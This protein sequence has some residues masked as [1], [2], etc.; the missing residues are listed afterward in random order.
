MDFIQDNKQTYFAA[1]FEYLISRCAE[2]EKLVV[3][4]EINEEVFL[5]T[6][7]GIRNLKIGKDVYLKPLY[8]DEPL[9]IGNHINYYLSRNDKVVYVVNLERHRF[10]GPNVKKLV[11]GIDILFAPDFVVNKKEYRIKKEIIA[12][13]KIYKSKCI[14][15]DRFDE[16][17]FYLIRLKIV[18][19]LVDVNS[20]D[21]SKIFA[22]PGQNSVLPFKFQI[23]NR[24]SVVYEERRQLYNSFY[25]VENGKAEYIKIT[26]KNRGDSLIVRATTDN[27]SNIITSDFVL[28][29]IKADELSKHIEVFNS[30]YGAFF[31]DEF[32]DLYKYRKFEKTRYSY[33]KETYS[34]PASVVFNYPESSKIEIGIRSALED[35]VIWFSNYDSLNDPFDLSGRI[36]TRYSVEMNDFYKQIV[37]TNYKTIGTNFLTFCST[38]REDN[39]LMWSHYGDS[40]KGTCIRYPMLDIIKTI[41]ND[42]GI[43][44]CFYGKVKYK[45][46]RPVFSI[47]FTTFRFV[48]IQLAIL[49]FNII[50]MFEK[51]KDWGY[52]NEFRFLII[53]SSPAS[54][55][56]ASTLKGSE[57]ILGNN[58]PV[59]TYA[60]YI[61]NFFVKHY[62]LKLSDSEYKLR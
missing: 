53:P 23:N 37:A 21:P 30:I 28:D 62:Q 60:S 16:F 42:K 34:I 3:S 49:R 33:D 24:T 35:N 38:S 17:L 56:Y 48:D 45:R 27:R 61:S 43:G 7:T 6:E 52:E 14:H 32:I 54:S 57:I 20:L 8:L 25:R 55:G 10:T 50:C 40:H 19:N 18:S 2:N 51:Y 15:I 31:P 4:R 29:T 47:P 12:L 46:N 59:T 9:E 44:I 5:Y 39:I 41:E 58:F 11:R 13:D 26:I 22:K 1:I 36:P